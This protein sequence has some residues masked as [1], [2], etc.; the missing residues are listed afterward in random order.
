MTN[1][2]VPSGSQLR[3][4]G[5]SVTNNNTRFFRALEAP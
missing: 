4:D 3:A 1:A 5:F 2:V